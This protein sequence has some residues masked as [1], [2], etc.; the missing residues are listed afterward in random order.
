VGNPRRSSREV[1]LDWDTKMEEGVFLESERVTLAFLMS[2]GCYVRLAA[3]LRND[4]R[5]EDFRR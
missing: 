1:R 4:G 2:M 3:I 5:E